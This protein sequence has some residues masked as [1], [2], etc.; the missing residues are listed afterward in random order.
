MSQL[1]S[2]IQYLETASLVKGTTPRKETCDEGRPF[3]RIHERQKRLPNETYSVEGLEHD[4]GHL[5]AVGLR[6]EGSLSEKDRVLLG[7]NAELVVEGVVP[8]LLHVVP[9]MRNTS[10]VKMRRHSLSW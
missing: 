3:V 10:D 4:L 5:L 8:D 9:A 6:V 2:T 1:S 7:G